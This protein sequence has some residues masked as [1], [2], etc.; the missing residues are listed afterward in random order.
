[1]NHSYCL[2]KKFLS[3]CPTVKTWDFLLFRQFISSTSLCNLMEGDVYGGGGFNW[4]NNLWPLKQWRFHASF[5]RIKRENSASRIWGSASF[6][7]GLRP[8]ER[9][10][11][12][13]GGVK[14]YPLAKHECTTWLER[15]HVFHCRPKYSIEN[16]TTCYT[17][18]HKF[19]RGGRGEVTVVRITLFLCTPK[20]NI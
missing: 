1:M 7:R 13:A 11:Q 12:W 9:N 17:N 19:R 8:A 6:M 4:D 14:L 15:W 20:I 5:S 3:S 10:A 16:D 18:A 2:I